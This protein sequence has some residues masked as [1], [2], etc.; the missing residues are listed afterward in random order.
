ML[1]FILQ[2]MLAAASV[3]IIFIIAVYATEKKK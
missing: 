3:I 2:I 1:N